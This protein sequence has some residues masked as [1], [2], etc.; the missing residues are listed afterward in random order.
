MMLEQ[1]DFDRLG[2]SRDVWRGRL[3]RRT[4]RT[5]TCW[6]WCGQVATDGYGVMSY[7]DGPRPH[8]RVRKLAAHRLAYWVANPFNPEM[9][10]LGVLHSCN[11]P[12]CVNP[13]HLRLGTHRDN[14]LDA[15]V[16][17]TRRGVKN[18]SAR[19]TEEQVVAIREAR[20][21]GATLEALASEYGVS[22]SLIDLIA[23]GKT[24][25]HLSGPIQPSRGRRRARK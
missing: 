8:G 17:G 2:L 14:M 22:V 12:L 4:R 15:V 13:D 6:L 18:P 16:A 25:S 19:L 11:T 20:G 23:R 9:P 24:W 1:I 10:K 5:E 21:T 3:E 7:R